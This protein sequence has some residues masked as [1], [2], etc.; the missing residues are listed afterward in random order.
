[1]SEDKAVTNVPIASSENCK[2]CEGLLAPEHQ[3][4]A[5]CGQQRGSPLQFQAFL[6]AF[7][8]DYFTFDSKIFRS[9]K[10]LL[11]KPGVLVTEFLAGR[12]VRYIAPLRIFLFSSIIFFLLLGL[13][14]GRSSEALGSELDFFFEVI[15]PK[16]VLLFLPLFALLV[17][18]FFG[19]RAGYLKHFLFSTYLHSF[20]FILGILYWSVSKLLRIVGMVSFNRVFLGL[21]LVAVLIYL[22]V[23]LKRVYRGTST[24]KHA[25]RYAGLLLAYGSLLVIAAVVSVTVLLGVG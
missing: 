11:F 22:W 3:Y 25:L 2:N 18:L 5:T 17:Q 21:Y 16:L 9:L 23:A 12:R 24:P 6:A 19:T 13:G 4:C 14:V 8:K 7:L 10:P 1:M 20:I 15:L